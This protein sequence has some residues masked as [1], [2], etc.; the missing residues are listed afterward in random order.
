MVFSAAA[1]ANSKHT[2]RG[3][4]YG[5]LIGSSLAPVMWTPGLAPRFLLDCQGNG[6]LRPQ[7]GALTTFYPLG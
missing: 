4:D 7:P 5:A 3:A 6:I 1:S 2:L